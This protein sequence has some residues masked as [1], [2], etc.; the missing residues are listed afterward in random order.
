MNS[1]KANKDNTDKENKDE[2]SKKKT[3]HR[4]IRIKTAK[5]IVQT[6]VQTAQMLPAN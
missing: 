3:T 6:R 5:K 4:M 1:A 2:N